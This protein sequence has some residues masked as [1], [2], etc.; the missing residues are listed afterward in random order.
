[1]ANLTR[2]SARL[3]LALCLIPLGPMLVWWTA[4]AGQSAGL[5]VSESFV[6]LAFAYPWIWLP[7]ASIG[8]AMIIGLAILLLRQSPPKPLR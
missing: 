6:G 5:Q 1:M 3:L 8:P 7:L 2:F 4:A